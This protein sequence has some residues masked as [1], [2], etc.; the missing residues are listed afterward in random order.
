MISH[1]IVVVGGGLAALRAAIEAGEHCDCAVFS[2][3]FP[4]RS[5]SGA[6]QGG[7][8]AA[9]ANAPDGKDDSPARHA[10][11]T[12]KGSDFLAD[13]PA[14]EAMTNDAPGCIFELDHWGAPFSR[15]DD[16]TIA[17]RPFGGAGFP[18]TCFSADKTGHVLL[19]TMYE[20]AV[21]R[22]VRVYP[23]WMA[24]A[25][26]VDN[27]V[28]Y[29]LVAMD[30]VRGT[31]EMIKADA[32]IFGT[33]GAGRTYS[34][35]TNAL[36]NTGS[37]MAV[38]YNAGIGLKDMEFIQFH[39]T[40]LYGTNILITE[41][42]RAEG[43]YLLNNKGERF[44]EKYAPKMME[45]GPRDIVARGIQ[46][47]INEG[48]GFDNAYVHLDLRHLG[49]EKILE[50]LP[51]IRDITISFAGLDPIDQPIPIQPG[52]H[53]TMGGIDTDQDGQ[54]EAAGLYAAGECA[55]V[56]VHGANRL[57]GNSLLDVIVFGRRA[58]AKA[59]EYVQNKAPTPGGEQVLQARLQ[60]IEQKIKQLMEGKGKEDLAAVRREMA[61][62]MMEQVGVFRE[63]GPMED[64]LTKI[65]GLQER[66]KHGSVTYRGTTYNL[67]IVR[68]LELE[69]MLQLTEIIA[70]GA[71]NR[72]ESRGSHCRYDYRDR[73]DVNWLKHTVAHKSP[74]GPKMSYKPV[75]I[76][77]YQPEAR[78]Y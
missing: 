9:L 32:V 60:E 63:Q 21:K 14:V 74:E 53:Y 56:S 49:R 59:A 68:N 40:S 5:H 62:T 51:G 66:Y 6:A 23:E 7:I 47:E 65:R 46:T 35:S 70:L 16:G 3:V 67:D 13:Q 19:H 20:Q 33:G 10:Y 4:I 73:D 72:Q 11:D 43:G 64:A 42:A 15:Y 12:I 34:R 41:G 71:L 17:Q 78:K 69:S 25:L 44:M 18:R 36:V 54:T 75:A 45:L 26:A 28:C 30:L 52:Q 29:G 2:Q 37:A 50:R 55:C 27:G 48:R 58:G 39:P 61:E 1:Q 77:T 22:G 24:L 31:L 38:A 57:G 76:T 8:N